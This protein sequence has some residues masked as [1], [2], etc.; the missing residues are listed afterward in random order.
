[1]S[2]WLS[3]PRE[4]MIIAGIIFGERIV[5]GVPVKKLSP[6]HKS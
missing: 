6:M 1:M 3:A 4:D 2:I 5:S